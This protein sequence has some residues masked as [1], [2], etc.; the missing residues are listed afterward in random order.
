MKQYIVSL[1]AV[2]FTAFASVSFGQTNREPVVIT[3]PSGMKISKVFVRDNQV[4]YEAGFKNGF[5]RFTTNFEGVLVEI[6][7]VVEDRLIASGTHYG[8]G[9]WDHNGGFTRADTSQHRLDY[10]VWAAWFEKNVTLRTTINQRR[11]FIAEDDA[12]AVL[13][14]LSAITVNSQGKLDVVL[15]SSEM[16]RSVAKSE[17][18]V[19]PRKGVKFSLHL[20]DGL[21]Y[22][23]EQIAID[24]KSVA[25]IV[26]TD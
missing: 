24:G 5:V 3:P 21:L 9:G 23:V 13:W 20:H 26:L 11:S 12:A 25:A 10:A 22:P 6:H 2:F 14:E 4:N 7:S 17:F 1:L 8:S 16:S 19:L 18:G 15:I